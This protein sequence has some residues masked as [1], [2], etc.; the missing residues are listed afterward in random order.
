MSILFAN[1]P[2]VEDWLR[3]LGSYAGRDKALRSLC[4]GLIL[5]STKQKNE[6]L[7][8]GL[9]SLAKQISQAR[10][11]ARQLNH[12]PL[13]VATTKLYEA[14]R[15]ASDKVDAS[16]NFFVMAAYVVYQFSELFAWL[17]DAKVLQ[18]NSEPFYR[19]GIYSWVA[20]LFAG[21][22][23]I[24]RRILII[25]PSEDRL[26]APEKSKL[27]ARRMDR[28]TLVGLFADLVGGVNMLP[29]RFLWAG[30]LNQKTSATFFLIASIIGLYKLF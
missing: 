5:T 28:I 25:E 19:W 15:L 29:H 16:L 14:I 21:I 11:V 6:I 2:K 30:R 27:A 22:I 20:A 1:P 24:L 26:N 12:G 8:S 13:I 17:S 3:V 23:Q 7:A 9:Q 10:T 4:F 18:L